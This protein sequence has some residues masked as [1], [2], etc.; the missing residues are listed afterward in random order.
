MSQKRVEFLQSNPTI[1]NQIYRERY[2]DWIESGD[3]IL[4]KNTSSQ[5]CI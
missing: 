3:I 5:R 4:K 1:L 2:L